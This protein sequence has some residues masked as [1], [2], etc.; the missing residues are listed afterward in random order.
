MKILIVDDEPLIRRSLEKLFT[1][2]GHEVQTSDNGLDGFDRWLKINPDLVFLDVLMPGLTGPELLKKVSLPRSSKVI[3]IS[4]FTGDLQL[5]Q[6][7]Q[8]DLF[9][10]KPFENII[11]LYEK[12]MGLFK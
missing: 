10:Q 1:S 4:A 2:R 3:L 8:P 5:D 11:E 7:F 9:I 6:K 12:S